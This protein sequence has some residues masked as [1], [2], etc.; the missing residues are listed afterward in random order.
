M[1]TPQD[2]ITTVDGRRCTRTRVRTALTSTSTTVAA[3][4]TTNDAANVVQVQAQSSAEA[5]PSPPPATP[6]PAQASEDD[7]EDEPDDPPEQAQPVPTRA[8]P[9]PSSST[10]SVNNAPTPPVAAA[11]GRV[12]FDSDD[13]RETE[14]ARIPLSSVRGPTPT[15]VIRLSSQADILIASLP[16]STL[17]TSQ[18]LRQSTMEAILEEPQPTTRPEP[19]PEPTA[20]SDLL[21]DSSG[22]I[23]PDPDSDS[24]QGGLTIS[25][26]NNVG[27][28]VGGAIGGFA[29][30]VLVSVLLFLCL[31][32]RRSREPLLK[33]PKGINEKEEEEVGFMG[34]VAGASSKLKAFTA[35]IGALFLG[36]REKMARPSRQGYDRHSARSSMSSVYTA[37]VGNRGSRSMSEPPSRLREQ[38]GA[39]G[40]RFGD[41]MPSLKRSRTLLQKKPDSLVIG[42]KSPFPGIVDD[43]VTRRSSGA[44]N[45][46]ADP[47][48]D[49]NFRQSIDR[50]VQNR[51]G[52]NDQQRP[53]ITPK[54]AVH[55][56]RSSRDPFASIL[57]QLEEA[58]GNRTPDWLRD[59]AHKR[60][61]SATTALRSHPPSTYTASV[62]TT[63][64]N[65]FLD[66]P[67]V[68]PVPKQP[69]PPDPKRPS[70]AYTSNLPTFNATLS[71][72]SRESSGSFYFG[73]PGPSRPTTNMFSEVSVMSTA[74]KKGRESDPFDLDRPEILGF[75]QVGGRQVRASVTRQSSRHNRTSTV[76]NWINLEDGLYAPPTNGRPGNKA[77]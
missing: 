5:A 25:S 41:R 32:R 65:S 66:P 6:S 40:H 10:A 2:S 71:T 20:G 26:N 33:W 63:A 44:E 56:N 11:P 19:E 49:G 42:A 31:K 13:S 21:G 61:Q 58:R 17:E 47:K 9:A 12:A 45:P 50:P 57:D 67:D 24:N 74:F 1:S 28:I 35:G 62:Y 22:M 54:A 7:V 59:T 18:S 70:N 27:S 16:S 30:V 29:A 39:L 53:P 60:T 43:P 8:P 72:T 14:A 36:I 69:L 48:N 52:L 75:G 46:F 3:Q 34:T 76:P 37:R 38:L 68:P 4:A 15:P 64:E 73:E 23:S 51:E 77:R 55:S